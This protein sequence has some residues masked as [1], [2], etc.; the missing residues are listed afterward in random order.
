ME[1]PLLAVE[2]NLKT[3]SGNELSSTTNVSA[4][5]CFSQEI[6][7]YANSAESALYFLKTK[8]YLLRVSANSGFQ[9]WGG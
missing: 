7:K 5:K 2:R 9:K 3:T 4:K 1:N 6:E 8:S